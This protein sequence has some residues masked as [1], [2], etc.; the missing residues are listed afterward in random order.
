MIVELIYDASCPNVQA[1]RSRLIQAFAKTRTSARWREWER[2]S[3]DTPDYAR[4]YGSPTILVNSQDVGGVAAD[5]EIHSCRLYTDEAGNLQPVPMVEFISAALLKAGDSVSL[6]DPTAS[7][8]GN[9]WRGLL[10]SLPAVGAAL[11][12][13]LTCPVCWPAYT[14]ILS[15]LGLS[16]VDYTP[17][18][19]PLTLAFLLAAVG[20]L[21]WQG[22]RNQNFLP[23]ILGVAASLAVL[24]GKF[25]I[26]LD[27]LTYGG[28]ALLF[29]AMLWGSW[30][31]EATIT[32]CPACAPAGQELRDRSA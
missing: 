2:S 11:L 3:A 28:I 6:N 9:P 24:I 18:L 23:L 20:A 29:I 19:F 27:W 10:A 22:R 12:P 8:R 25:A 5:V 7:V 30:R 4:S 32:S 21:A 14:T 31:R 13:K 26:E 1:A 17:Y 16:F 15:A